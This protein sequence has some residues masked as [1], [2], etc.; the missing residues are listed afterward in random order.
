MLFRSQR[1]LKLGSIKQNHFQLK[2]R[3]VSD[4]AELNVR[5]QQVIQGVPNYY[6]EQRF[7]H[8][9]GNLQLAARLFA[10][11]SIPD[12]QL[13][14]LAL[15]A[16]RSMLFNQQVSARVREQLFLTLLPGS[17]VQLDG[18]GSVFCVPEQNEEIR[19]RLLEQ[20]LHPTAV[21]PGIGKEIGRAS[22]REIV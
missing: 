15:S 16:S 13:R 17:V 6:G 12:R 4:P 5:L 18:S 10:G 20:D 11:Q 2:L 7:G 14:G 9:G 1:R 21:L 8:F 22:C 3:N 19:Q